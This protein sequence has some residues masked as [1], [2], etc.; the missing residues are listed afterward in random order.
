[1][2]KLETI[3]ASDVHQ[4][5]LGCSEP[6]LHGADPFLPPQSQVILELLLEGFLV[7]QETCQVNNFQALV[8]VD[9][10]FYLFLCYCW[11]STTLHMMN[12]IFNYH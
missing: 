3:P 7:R 1:M 8:P 4:V 6:Y 5:Q 2:M 10:P 11:C 9:H 12:I